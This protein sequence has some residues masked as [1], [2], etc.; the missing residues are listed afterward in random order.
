VARPL[1]TKNFVLLVIAHFTQ[2]LGYASM[3]LLP[4][5]LQHLGASRTEI[6]ALMATSAIGGLATRPFVAWALDRI[7]RKPTLFVGTFLLVVS[8]LMIAGV[9]SI[10]PL[11]YLERIVFGVGVG[12]LFSGY[13]TFAAD[14]IPEERRTEG[15]ALFGISGLL[16]L[17]VNP[18]SDRLGIS[19]PELRLFLP[20]VGVFI[21][22][23]ASALFFL[24]EPDIGVDKSTR[25]PMRE[26]LGTLL[27]RP[28]WPVWFATS[29]FSGF[30]AVFMAYATVAAER[31]GVE[32][33]ASL[34]FSY[35]MGAV[36][37]RLFGA[38]LPDRIGPSKMVP[39]ALGSYAVALYLTSHA[40]TFN[41]FLLAALFAG[42]GHGYCFP[43]LSGQAITRT[44]DAFRGSAMAFF[45]A[46][47]GLSELLFSPL[48]G[49][50]AD[51]RGDATMFRI[52]SMSGVGGIILWGMLEHR[53]GREPLER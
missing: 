46:L 28:L 1:I 11:I 45:T 21:A 6:G 48:F 18:L 17:L 3:L 41:A 26:A 30:V 13:F 29:V 10:G 36:T 9:D 50:I 22:L 7:G 47:W 15:L 37:V 2:A 5:Y 43:I 38:R 20:I 8:M 23:G 35:A 32:H 40:S 34:W 16:P 42:L 33:P 4:L 31:Q 12:A 14:L 49:A 51:A 44:P 39:P 53:Y 19:P 27:R 25:P 24:P 52:A